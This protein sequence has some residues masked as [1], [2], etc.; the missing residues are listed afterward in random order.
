MRLKWLWF[1]PLLVPLA[2]ACVGDD[3]ATTAPNN[4]FDS[5]SDATVAPDSAAPVD[6]AIDTGIV[7][8]KTTFGEQTGSAHTG[9][10]S[11]TD[12]QW[13][14]PTLNFGSNADVLVHGS[15]DG[16]GTPTIGLLHFDLSSL[17]TN[18][19]V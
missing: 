6:A 3:P 8:V 19:N 17:P 14:N 7:N 11:D 18:S 5:G 13:G 16:G 12:I 15:L 4:D 1:A 2:I 10:T 9:V